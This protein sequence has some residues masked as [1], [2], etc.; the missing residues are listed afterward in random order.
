MGTP[1]RPGRSGQVVREG[2]PKIVTFKL[3]PKGHA[4]LSRLKERKS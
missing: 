4:K 2:V 3:K 1:F